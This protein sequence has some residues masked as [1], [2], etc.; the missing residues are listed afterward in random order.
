MTDRFTRARDEAAT[1]W[2][3]HYCGR[4]DPGNMTFGSDEL[5]KAFRDGW[6][7]RRMAA[8]LSG[9]SAALTA[10]ALR[11]Y[12]D[13]GG[14]FTPGD[15]RRAADIVDIM[16]NELGAARNELQEAANLFREYQASH[17][18]KSRDPTRR[19]EDRSERFAKGE[20]NRHA[21]DRIE[22]FLKGDDDDSVFVGAAAPDDPEAVAHELTLLGR[23]EKLERAL[24]RIDSINDNPATFNVR[25]N[26]VIVDALGVAIERNPAEI[27]REISIS[28]VDGETIKGVE[29]ESFDK[30]A[31]YCAQPAEPELFGWIVGNGSGDKWRGWDQVG[32]PCWVDDRDAATRYYR[33]ADAETVHREDEDAWS[34]EHYGPETDADPLI[35]QAI[36][37]RS[38][39]YRCDGW[40]MA[41]VTKRSGAV[42]YIVEDDRG[43]LLVMNAA[44]IGLEPIVPES[45]FEK[46][47]QPDPL[48][49][50]VHPFPQ[51][52]HRVRTRPKGWKPEGGAI[53]APP[54]GARIINVADAD[55]P[56]ARTADPRWS[57]GEPVMVNGYGPYILAPKES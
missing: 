46:T 42:R 29:H 28:L 45:W 3:A 44:Q 13:T 6:D 18:A 17:L 54:D 14:P 30:A 10:S 27:L 33:R 36:Q 48:A 22:R 15:A 43:M 16:W 20:R 23:I 38:G 26:D 2:L 4:L 57:K 1:A 55:L 51:P 53:A 34:I 8:I 31:E 9:D 49:G 12:G 11:R 5:K 24:R 21:A 47:G 7:H 50:M 52:G 41:I 40:I 19:A 32:N 56:N 35:G 25:I 39:D 37:K